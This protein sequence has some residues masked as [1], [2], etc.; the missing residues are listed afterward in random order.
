MAVY[1]I[2]KHNNEVLSMVGIVCYCDSTV[3][4]LLLLL[5]TF[6]LKNNLIVPGIFSG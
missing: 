3:L 4:R 5:S 2:T 6:P 1:I